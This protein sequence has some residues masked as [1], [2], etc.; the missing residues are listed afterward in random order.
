MR[1][2]LLNFPF[3][4]SNA[5]TSKNIIVIIIQTLLN[6]HNYISYHNEMI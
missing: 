1:W 6:I 4:F 3:N 5:A 2:L